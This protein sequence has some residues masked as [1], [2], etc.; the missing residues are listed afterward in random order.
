M[1]VRDMG[2]TDVEEKKHRLLSP[3]QH[4]IDPGELPTQT[5][6]VARK[7]E[8]LKRTPQYCTGL[9]A[10]VKPV[11][12]SRT[13]GEVSQTPK[14]TNQIGTFQAKTVAVLT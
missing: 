14:T 12:S 3:G 2:F 8:M 11:H 7:P 6:G 9:S 10:G 13:N 1:P 5:P 4:L